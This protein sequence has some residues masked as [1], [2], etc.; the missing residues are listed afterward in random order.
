MLLPRI[1]HNHR[2]FE[3]LTIRQLAKIIGI[4]TTSLWRF[5]QGRPVKSSTWVAIVTWLL[6]SE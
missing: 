6:T 5:E 2:E 1:V 4:E 3:R